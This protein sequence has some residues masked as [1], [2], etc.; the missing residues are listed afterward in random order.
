MSDTMQG[1]LFATQQ[2]RPRRP[3]QAPADRREQITAAL[4]VFRPAG[5]AVK[6]PSDHRQKTGCA[7]FFKR[8]SQNHCF[9]EVSE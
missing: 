2:S 4:E 9:F 6:I 5:G 8:V 3:R 7:G 1:E